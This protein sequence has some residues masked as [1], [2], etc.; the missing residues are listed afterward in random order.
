M[1]LRRPLQI[2]ATA[3]AIFVSATFFS[4]RS[5]AAEAFAQTAKAPKAEPF[6]ALTYQELRPRLLIQAEAPTPSTVDRDPE[7][8]NVKVDGYSAQLVF[9]EKLYTFPEKQ[10]FRVLYISRSNDLNYDGTQ[11]TD[12]G[13]QLVRM[14]LQ[15][16]DANL[17]A[18]GET[19][20]LATKAQPGDPVKE[21]TGRTSERT[22]RLSSLVFNRAQVRDVLL[23]PL[24]VLTPQGVIPGNSKSQIISIRK[25]RI[26]WT[27][28]HSYDLT[29]RVSP[30]PE[31]LRANRCEAVIEYVSY[32]P[33]AR[34]GHWVHP[35]NIRAW[36]IWG[37]TLVY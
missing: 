8:T 15:P 33:D 23:N 26:P 13:F 9:T 35:A 20:E 24:D 3:L 5:K 28:T 7:Y 16:V 1:N 6:V 12:T 22:S 31:A 25:A 34:F 10:L 27:F 36:K 17:R 19:V 21:F 11:M 14:T 4:S 2:T 37:M 30:C 32:L 29:V 18:T